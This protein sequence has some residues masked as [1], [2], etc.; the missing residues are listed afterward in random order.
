M[1]AANGGG[2]KITPLLVFLDEIE[3]KFQRY[4]LNFNDGHSH[5]ITGEPARC[6]GSSK[7]KMA[8]S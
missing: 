1:Y 2:C 4:P 5:G 8:A 6:N 7:S 3:T